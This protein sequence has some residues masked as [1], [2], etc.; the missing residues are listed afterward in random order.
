M[1][2]S[3]VVLIALA[4]VAGALGAS[5][6][7]AKKKKKPA[8]PKRVERV[9]EFTYVCPCAGLFQLGSALGTNVGGGPIAVGV[10]EIYLSATATDTTG[11]PVPVDINQDTNG[12][13]LNDPVGSFCGATDSPMLINGGLEMRVFIGS[14]A[15]CPGPAAGGTITF[16]LSNLP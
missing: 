5:P 2:K 4:L 8:A 14:P 13:G 9:V 3:L 10:D 15:I 11:Q 16:T 6:A 12:D 1:R 7:L